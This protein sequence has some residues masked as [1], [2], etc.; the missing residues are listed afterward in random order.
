MVN[1]DWTQI[2]TFN[3]ISIHFTGFAIFI[4]ISSFLVMSRSIRVEDIILNYT[5]DQ[6]SLGHTLITHPGSHSDRNTT[7]SKHFQFIK[8]EGGTI[9]NRRV[10]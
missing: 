2:F 6:K 7:S 1:K 10:N 8:K 4:L 9:D 3:D 5:I